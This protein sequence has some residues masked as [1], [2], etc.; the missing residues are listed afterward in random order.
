MPSETP[1][2]RRGDICCLTRDL[3]CLSF[4]Y[5]MT[6]KSSRRLGNHKEEYITLIDEEFKIKAA[7][8]QSQNTAVKKE[9]EEIKYNIPEL[10]V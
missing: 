1:E 8:L 2:R 5:T 7:L 6:I 10:F 3:F 9:A 4:A